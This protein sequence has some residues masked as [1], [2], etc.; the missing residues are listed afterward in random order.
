[1]EL[2]I[3]C[4]RFVDIDFPTQMVAVDGLTA[5]AI[6]GLDLPE[7]P[8]CNIRNSSCYQSKT[9][10]YYSGEDRYR[11]QD[12]AIYHHSEDPAYPVCTSTE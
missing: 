3:L 7:T 8:E 5:K 1:M 12:M 4:L 6:L 2:L 10:H 11:Q 9:T